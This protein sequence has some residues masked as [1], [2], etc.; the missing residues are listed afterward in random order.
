MKR[1][2][3]FSA[4]TAAL[5]ASAAAADLTPCRLKGLEREVRCGRIEVPENPAAPTARTLT[6][7]FAVVPALAKNKAPDPL[8]VLAGGP[9]Q[10]AMGVAGQMQPV[11]AKLNARRDIVYVDQRGTGRSNAL[12]CETSER[13]VPLAE[14]MD[15]RRAVA[16]LAECV[17]KLPADTRQYA[18][19]IAM[20]DLDGVRAALGAEQ[21][22]LWGASYGTR[23]ALDYLRQFPQHVRSVV[24]DG[25][26]P[27]DMVLP[28]SFAV[29]ADAALTRLIEHCERDARCK[30]RHPSLGA[31]IDRL[32][33]AAAQGASVEIADPLTGKRETVRLDRLLATNLLRAPL[34]AP[35]L[36]A[37][38]PQAVAAAGGGDY[39]PLATLSLALAGAV[40]RNFADVMHFAVVCAEDL[41]RLTAEQVEAARRTRFG[42]ESVD[43]YRAA[44]AA[45]PSR[46][47]PAE[48]YRLPNADVPVLLLSG[49]ADPATPPRH[50]EGVA[51]ALP[52]ARHLAA[53]NVGHGVSAQGC[54]P[55]MIA[56]FVRQ[57]SFEGIDGACLGKLPAPPIFAPPTGATAKP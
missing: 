5:V 21:I 29:D 41:P 51:K 35:A 13:L 56:R 27:P 17:A 50:G 6:I 37:V 55:E 26:A 10:A 34:Y 9:G 18:T 54:A 1:S 8:F 24:L 23:A 52:R 19:W 57:A 43:F 48:F 12:T 38:L 22:N 32:L 25:V 14:A 4:L 42:T 2:L 36:A 40:T 7:H 3:L 20:R 45:V 39:A 16:R 49:G 33:A 47:A 44:C 53:P 11:L 15:H 46:P 30:A 31:D 28:A